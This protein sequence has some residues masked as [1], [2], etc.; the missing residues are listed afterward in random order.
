MCDEEKGI[1]SLIS[2]FHGSGQFARKC[3][4]KDVIVEEEVAACPAADYE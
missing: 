3:E 1:F 2:L 4:K